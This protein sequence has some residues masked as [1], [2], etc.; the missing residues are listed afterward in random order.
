MT[1]RQAFDACVRAASRIGVRL[2]LFNVLLVFLPVAGLA[3][4]DAYEQHLLEV[5]ERAMVQHGRLASAML[6]AT[7][8][9]DG[10]AAQEMLDRLAGT[11][12]ARVRVLDAD[13]RVVADS[14]RAQAVDRAGD[15]AVASYG[16]AEPV[17]RA[18]RSS[19]LYR[20]GA[21]LGRRWRAL[22]SRPS[23]ST[24]SAIAQD[25]AG[26][27]S[28]PEIAR[29]LEGRYGSATRPSSGGQ[30]SLTLYSALP[31]GRGDRT[32]G[33]VLV[34]QS[35]WRILQRLYDVRIRMFEVFVVSLVA[36]A[37]LGIV[38]ATT[39]VR[40]LR[41]LRADARALVNRAARTTP[42]FRGTHRRD[43]IGDLARALD[44]I[45]GRLDA[46]LQFTERFAAD[47]SHEF[48]NPLA[49]IRA[50]TEVLADADRPDDRARFRAR[51]DR[52]IRRLETLLSRV[53]D[54]T[55]VDAGLEGEPTRAVDLVA[56]VRDLVQARA[57][58]ARPQVP[59]DLV[60][61]DA[62]LVVRATAERLVQVLTNLIDNAASFSPDGGRI[63][64]VVAR[65]E[66]RVRVSVTDEGPGVPPA[67]RERIFD[68]FF[69][70]RPGQ[71][72]AREVHAGLGLSIAR[73]IAET[74]G[75]TLRCGATERGARFDLVLPL[76][77][78]NG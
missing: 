59:I 35:T 75:G 52:D 37:L 78:A 45:T 65:D 71:E 15:E 58:A 9:I 30:R 19:M 38:A 16:R 25:R 46:H 47:V 62:P 33:V 8:R 55:A 73:T 27:L 74:Y 28:A 50:S 51:I 54:I 76:R 7:P 77:D 26:T 11:L 61:P 56:L 67:H 1:A 23:T 57:E 31:V 60:A 66:H 12:D 48:R 63:A 22:V 6:G 64:V 68:R 13:A 43:E 41:R 42:R 18:L 40:P 5:Q 36:A 20:T 24:F 49:S 39:I 29:A 44:E 14:H 21:W 69:T 3:S 4:L 32:V 72:D 34:S 2:L 17:A 53:R 70:H 10:S